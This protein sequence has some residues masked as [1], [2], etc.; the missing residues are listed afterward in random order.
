MKCSLLALSSYLDGELE[1]GR[2]AEVEA[3]LEGLGGA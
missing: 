1:T 3:H 2:R